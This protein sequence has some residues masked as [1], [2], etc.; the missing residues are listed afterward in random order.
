MMI[1]VELTIEPTKVQVKAVR[2]TTSVMR[3]LLKEKRETT[4]LHRGYNEA[5]TRHLA[6]ARRLSGPPLDGRTGRFNKKRFRAP[7]DVFIAFPL[8][9]PRHREGRHAWTPLATC[10]M[11]MDGERRSMNGVSLVKRRKEEEIKK[12]GK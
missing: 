6:D 8:A 11:E 7:A 10:E 3:T 2:M 1:Q 9:K 5:T 4:R 12:V